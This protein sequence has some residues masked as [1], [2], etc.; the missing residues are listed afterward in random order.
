MS[1]FMGILDDRFSIA[2]SCYAVNVKDYEDS[3]SQ[4]FMSAEAAF[5]HYLSLGKNAY[6]E[7]FPFI[8]PNYYSSQLGEPIPEGMTVFEQ[9][10][11]HGAA[12]GLSP[13]PYFDP[14]YVLS[15]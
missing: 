3:V 11:T 15:Q 8:D 10:V 13:L 9:Y 5:E 6:P 14:A 4:Q 7:L 1:G 2:A 12:L